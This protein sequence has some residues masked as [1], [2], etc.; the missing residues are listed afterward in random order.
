MTIFDFATVAVS[1]IL[2]LA[3][4]YLLESIVEAFR[5]RRR[6]RL[7]WLPF[8]WA[9]CVLVQQFQFWWALYELNGMPSLSVGRFSLLLMLAALLFLAGALVLPSGESDYPEDLANYFSSDGSWGVAALALFNLSAVAIN[10]LLFDTP[11][12][13]T[14]NQRNLILLV[15][16]VSVAITRSRRWQ[17]G[18]TGVYVIALAA[19]EIAATRPV[20]ENLGT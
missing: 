1:F 5:A 2:G 4:T 8:V 6:C 3:V 18:L 14:V 10:V 12:T 19:A 11:L 9:A 15:I 13:D 17:V 20:Y 16:T 7:D